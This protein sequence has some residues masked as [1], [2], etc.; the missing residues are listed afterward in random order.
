VYVGIKHKNEPDKIYYFKATA[1]IIEHLKV[2]MNALCNTRKGLEEG[3]VVSFIGKHCT[4]QHIISDVVGFQAKELA[5]DRIQACQEWTE[6]NPEKIAKRVEEHRSG[7][8]Y[9][10]RIVVDTDGHLKDGYTAYLTSKMLDHSTIENVWVVKRGF[11][12]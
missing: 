6:P 4:N 11:K 12:I 7:G 9:K 10:T 8:E 3:E 1:E 2:G 5:M